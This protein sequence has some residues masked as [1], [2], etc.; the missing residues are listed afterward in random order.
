MSERNTLDVVIPAYKAKFLPVLLQSLADQTS[1][2]FAVIV[3]DDCS[4]ENLRAI[5]DR[6]GGHLSIRYVRLDRNL[7]HTDLAGHWN[8]SVAFSKAQ[9]VIVPGDDDVLEENCIEAFWNTAID[10]PVGSGVFSF[11]VRVIDEN[12]RIIRDGIRAASAA[13]AAQY[14]RQ[15]LGYEVYAVPAAYVFARSLFD[16]LGGFVSF[17]NGWHSDDATW[18]LFAARSAMTPIADAFVRWRVSSVNISPL[19]QRDR[20][21]STRATLAFLSWIDANRS[22]LGLTN[23]DVHR[24]TD[25]SICWSIYPRIAHTPYAVWLSTMWRTSRFLRRH[26]SKSLLRHL[27]RF[28]HARLAQRPTERAS[29]STERGS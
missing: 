15:R 19:M 26:S 14:I 5:C 13:S 20:I 11:G 2:N 6:F 4:P 16:E 28:A 21:R 23:A 8:R 9:W 12:D 18:A 24:L 1:K 3:V 10:S 7:G 27:V 29:R 17:D 25:D 22:R